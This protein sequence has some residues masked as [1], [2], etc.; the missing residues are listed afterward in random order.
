[1][2]LAFLT[3][4]IIIGVGLLSGIYP[5]WQAGRVRPLETIRSG[6]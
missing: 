2:N 6:G 3:L 1:M 4:A 5:A